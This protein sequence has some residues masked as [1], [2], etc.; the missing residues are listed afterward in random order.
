MIYVKHIFHIGD[1]SCIS[2]RQN[3][4]A[5]LQV[6][7]K[8]CFFKSRPIVLPDMEST[9][10]S[11]TTSSSSKRNVHLALPLGGSEQANTIILAS[12]SPVALGGIGGVTRI[13]RYTVELSPLPA[14]AL[15]TLYIVTVVVQ[16]CFAMSS[17]SAPRHYFRPSSIVY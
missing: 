8:W 2:L 10:C 9:I 16:S 12:T 4:P 7:L 11:S 5:L 1:K 14:N 3:T 13:F 15:L 17:S 6:R